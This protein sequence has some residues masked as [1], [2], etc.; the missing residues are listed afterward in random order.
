MARLARQR[1]HHEARVGFV[2]GLLGLG[3]DPARLRPALEGGIAERGKTPGGLAG[4]G[5]LGGGFGQFGRDVPDQPGVAGQT[6]KVI[7]AVLLTPGHDRIAGEPAIAAQDDAH[8]GPAGAD[9]QDD[10]CQFIHR[11][12]SAVDVGRAQLGG[13]QM[14]ATENVERQVTIPVVIA[15]EEAAF[16]VAMQRVVGGVEVEDDLLGRGCV[17]VEKQLHQQALDGSAIVSDAVIAAGLFAGVLQPVQSGLAGEGLTVRPACR[18]L[19]GA[20]CQHRVTAQRVVVEQVLPPQCDAEN[21]LHEHGP[22][23]VLDQIRHARIIEAGSKPTDQIDRRVG[24]CQEKG[25]GVGSDVATIESGHHGTARGGLE[26]DQ[27][28]DTLC[29]HRA[30]PPLSVKAL[31]QKNFRRF[32]GPMHLSCVRN[33]G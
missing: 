9:L 29:L 32:A 20:G 10:P 19:A 24:A 31:L 13:Q 23:R 33:A 16:L 25:A 5:A 4:L 2:A 1:G 15:V 28:Q 21:A 18:E 12:G 26:S 22:H 6:E 27:I 17:R 7:D 3:D 11:A 14:A 8:K 30:T